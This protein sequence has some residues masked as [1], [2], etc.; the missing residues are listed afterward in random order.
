MNG[1]RSRICYTVRISVHLIDCN[2]HGRRMK[3][4]VNVSDATR[5]DG[6]TAQER[7]HGLGVF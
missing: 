4:S 2:S 7:R 3:V 1:G 5:R 6:A